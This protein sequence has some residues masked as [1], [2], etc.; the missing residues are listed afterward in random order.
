[1]VK[2]S[3][4]LVTRLPRTKCNASTW[5]SKVVT[6]NHKSSPHFTK[7]PGDL[8]KRDADS[9]EWVKLNLSQR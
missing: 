7:L 2:N 6:K 8:A 1:M 9:N 5:N 4:L 3:K